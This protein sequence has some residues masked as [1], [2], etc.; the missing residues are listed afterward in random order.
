MQKPGGRVLPPANQRRP[1]THTHTS[2]MGPCQ[3]FIGKG[4]R[5]GQ[6]P[7]STTAGRP[8]FCE[9]LLASGRGANIH[10]SVLLRLLVRWVGW[11]GHP[12]SL[13][14][15]PCSCSSWTSCSAV[16]QVGGGVPGAVSDAPPGAP[17]LAGHDSPLPP[18]SP[19]LRPAPPL[20]LPRHPSSPLPS[21]NIGPTSAFYT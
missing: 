9:V 21:P 17:H 10:L 16:R 8:V 11:F 5:R 4:D 20:V 7:S 19:P 3:L 6:S 1:H 18:C 13:S 2:Y 14:F 15:L 12:E